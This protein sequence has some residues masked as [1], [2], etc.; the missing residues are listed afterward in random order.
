MIN[1]KKS[2]SQINKLLENS[3]FTTKVKVFFSYRSYGD[4]YDPY[5]A[6][7]T[8]AKLNPKTLKAY[9]TD[10]S[11]QAL[12]YKQYG[13][14]EIGAKEILCKDRYKNWFKKCSK[15]TID[16]DEYQ[17]F[18]EG[19]GQRMIMTDRPFKLIRIIVSRRTP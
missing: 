18:K 11:P 7:A 16:G 17:V 6:N 14:H 8:D 9:V 12:V 15:I 4:D 13:L 19:A 2:H 3:N 5:E 10:I 1:I